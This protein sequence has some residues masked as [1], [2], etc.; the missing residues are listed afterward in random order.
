MLK[1]RSERWWPP[2]AQQPSDVTSGCHEDGQPV[3]VSQLRMTRVHFVALAEQLGVHSLSPLRLLRFPAFGCYVAVP[4]RP[5]RMSPTPSGELIRVR[6]AARQCER[7]RCVPCQPEHASTPR[8]QRPTRTTT[9]ITAGGRP[10]D[11]RHGRRGDPQPGTVNSTTGSLPAAAT[12]RI[13]RRAS[14]RLVAP[15]ATFPPL[16]GSPTSHNSRLHHGT[17][18]TPRWVRTPS[19]M[20]AL[21]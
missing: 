14:P 17:P 12:S 3:R 10:H 1:R 16:R 9:M 7:D 21:A 15:Q 19:W 20:S 5:R 4:R 8:R 2:T 13:R 6:A 18:N 11:R